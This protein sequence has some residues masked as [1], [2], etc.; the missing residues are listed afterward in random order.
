MQATLAQCSSGGT[1]CN[2]PRLSHWSDNEQ[3]YGVSMRDA[4]TDSQLQLF[5]PHVIMESV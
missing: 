2:H 4:G 5:W 1:T 3:E